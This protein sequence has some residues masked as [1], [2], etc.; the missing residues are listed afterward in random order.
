[1][2]VK[3]TPGTADGLVGKTYKVEIVKIKLIKAKF[4]DKILLD[5]VVI[6]YKDGKRETIDGKKL[7]DSI[8]MIQGS[9]KKHTH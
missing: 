6:K 9:V 2:K 1:M 7:Y 5:E 4:I 3:Y 8:D